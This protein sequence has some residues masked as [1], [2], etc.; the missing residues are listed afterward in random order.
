MKAPPLERD[1]LM[2]AAEAGSG[3]SDW[4]DTFFIEALDQLL[5]SL[6]QDAAINEA[7]AKTRAL[8]FTNI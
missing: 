4:G 1:A 7:G 5:A 3:L 2:A 6:K 8:Q